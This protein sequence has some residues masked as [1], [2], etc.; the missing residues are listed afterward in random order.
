MHQNYDIPPQFYE[1]IEQY[2]RHDNRQ[3]VQTK[4]ELINLW[5]NALDAAKSAP[6][7]RETIAEWTMSAA[8]SSSLIHE[9]ELEAIHLMFGEL[10]AGAAGS[11]KEHVDDQWQTL[12]QLVRKLK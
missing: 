9:P 11:T 10:R 1:Q 7:Q 8:A 6:E 3:T 5:Q 2:I 4:P 12:K